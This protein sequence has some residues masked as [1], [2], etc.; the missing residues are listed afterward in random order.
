MNFK[1]SYDI[2][3]APTLGN[4]WYEISRGGKFVSCVPSAT[5]ILQSY[6]TSPQLLKWLAE[7]GWSESQR[8]KNEAGSKGT[9]VHTAIETLLNGNTLDQI[10]F[11][12]EEWYKIYCFTRWYAD[13]KPEII[14]LE[15]PIFSKKYGYAGRTD[16]ICKIDG[17][18]H[19]V[20]W[21][22]SRSIHKN[23]FLQF[24]AYAHAI[25][26]MTDLKIAETAGIQLGA[27]NKNGYRMVLSKCWPDDFERFLDVKRIW[28]YDNGIDEDH[29]APVLNLPNQIKL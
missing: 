20:D 11:S 21:K 3:L 29:E 25:E 4:H 2:K 19:L 6:P 16:C 15:M 22:T 27:A 9:R 17:R 23:F 13:Y 26:E 12:L 28:E 10:N 14:S 1:A 5:T 8:I 24:A 7:N 18:I